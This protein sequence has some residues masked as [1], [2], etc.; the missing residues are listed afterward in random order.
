MEWWTAFMIGLAGSLHCVGMC[1]PIA[2]A[3]PY[4]GQHRSLA[5]ANVLLYN[6]GRIFTYS[7]LGLVI[8]LLGKGLFLAGIQA[9][10]SIGLGILF[11][12]VA[13]F[14]INIESGILKLGIIRQLNNWVKIQLGALLKQQRWYNFFG[15]GVLNGLLPCG[16]VYMGIAGAVMA[17]SL[18]G[19]V[20]FMAF[21]GLGTL[22]LMLITALG[23]QFIDLKWRRKARRLMPYFLFL[24]AVLFLYRGLNF[25]LPL[26]FHLWEDMNQVPMCH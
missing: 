7:M 21:F 20:Q 18:W 17:S 15:I 8:G 14:S 23:G 25:Y 6:G 5:A 19:S 16:L 3:L 13:L 11:L 12:A 4:Q 1:G 22:P 10:L 2:L 26:Q 9:Y 24:F